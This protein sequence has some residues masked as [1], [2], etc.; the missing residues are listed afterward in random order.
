MA[1]TG[2][3]LSLNAIGLQDTILS[4]V[5][6]KNFNNSFFN[7]KPVQSTQS[8]IFYRSHTK[9]NPDGAGSTWPFD[10]EI[11]F[12]IDPKTSGDLLA[13]AY[14][15]CTLPAL[16]PDYGY[17]YQVG[18]AM[19]KELK[20]MVDGVTMDTI[21][22][23]WLI[24]H[25]EILASETEQYA[26]DALANGGRTK[27]LQPDSTNPIKVYVPLPFMFSRTYTKLPGN[28]DYNATNDTADK[29]DVT[30]KPYFYLCACTNQKIH[31]SITFNPIQFFSNT[32][33]D[34]TLQDISLITEEISLSEKERQ[35]YMNNRQVNVV[36]T[37]IK[38]PTQRQ[39][40]GDGVKNSQGAIQPGCPK[41]FKNFL[42]S[43]N[44]VKSFHWF[45]RNQDFESTTNS[46]NYLNRFNFT[47]NVLT[48]N[49]FTETEN[50]VLRDAHIYID[51][52]KQLGFLGSSNTGANYY[53]FVQTYNHGLSTPQRNIYTYSFSLNPKDPTPTGSLDFSILN[54][55]KTLLTGDVLSNATSNAYNLHLY[56]IGYKV[57]GFDR[58]YA[59]LLFS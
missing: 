5:K 32:V 11:R 27:N 42:V 12:E 1:G 51:G 44:P 16:D 26:T 56:Y 3:T 31:I 2:A 25:D 9:Y 37:L 41:N 50:Q 14:L 47:S 22:G 23:D 8:T 52:H 4:D 38:Q 30:F 43:N 53:K 54:S 39:D 7:Y 20:F 6:P 10:R 35:F 29:S 40:F 34:I 55:S 18:Q 49:I 24:L 17:S 36:N 48:S 19:I 59:N 58:G 13:N 28:W 15:K 45:F 46:S 33:T 21:P 57:V